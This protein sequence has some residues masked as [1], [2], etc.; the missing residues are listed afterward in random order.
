[1]TPGRAGATRQPRGQ[2]MSKGRGPG[3][4]CPS[5][6]CE[7]GWGQHAAAEPGVR[8]RRQGST[9]RGPTGPR[10]GLHRK[11]LPG[12]QSVGVNTH[13]RG[14]L[15]CCADSSFQRGKSRQETSE[16]GAYLGLGG[17]MYPA[18]PQHWTPQETNQGKF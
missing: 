16:E 1:M 8:G 14:T 3:G 18:R 12:P 13:L 2:G 11:P 6:P 9:C 5:G 7:D 4:Q 17:E 10:G 15:G